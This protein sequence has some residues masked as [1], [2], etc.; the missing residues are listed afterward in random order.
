MRADLT[1]TVCPVRHVRP[2]A[3]VTDHNSPR[4]HVWRARTI[5]L[6]ADGCDTNEITALGLAYKVVRTSLLNCRP[7]LYL[8]GARSR[9]DA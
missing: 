1:L 8:S 5:L 9:R 4:K 2:D 7:G 3:I 6:S